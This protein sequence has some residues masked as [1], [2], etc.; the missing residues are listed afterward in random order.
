MLCVRGDHRAAVERP[1][2]SAAASLSS[3]RSRPASPE[4]RMN[5]PPGALAPS[6]SSAKSV[7]SDSVIEAVFMAI[8]LLYP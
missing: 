2:A 7:V 5:A 6:I 1:R 3:D 8:R 4:L